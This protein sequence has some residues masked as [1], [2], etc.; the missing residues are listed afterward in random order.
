MAGSGILLF[1]PKQTT[2]LQDFEMVCFFEVITL[3]LSSMQAGPSNNFWKIAW[4]DKKEQMFYLAWG[5]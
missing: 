1:D 3:G 4:N 5:C 2:S